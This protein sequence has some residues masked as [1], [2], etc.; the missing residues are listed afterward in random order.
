[1]R[2]ALEFILR[3]A[4]VSR[5]HTMITLHRETVGHHSHGVACLALII[6]PSASRSLLIAA[7]FH[8]LSE[9]R[10]GD[11]PSPAKREFG[12]KDQV[13]ALENRL[14]L[15]AGIIFPELSKED[16]RTLKLA[17]IAHGALS[18]L[19]EMSLGNRRMRE[20]YDTFISYAH[21]IGL[22]GS[23]ETLFNL[24]EEMRHECE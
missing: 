2:K 9:H 22:T 15:E 16:A 13:D 6:D 19:R 18:C 14:M 11:I 7:L 12:I 23:A 24:I 5:Y 21:E 10:T 20:I 1:M 8:D 17:D 4:E 3:G